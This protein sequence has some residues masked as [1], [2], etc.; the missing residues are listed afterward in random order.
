M[1]LNQT[2]SKRVDLLGTPGAC[3]GDL[4]LEKRSQLAVLVGADG[5][6]LVHG[7]PF[8][9]GPRGGSP[10]VS[11][12]TSIASR[13]PGGSGCPSGSGRTTRRLGSRTETFT[14]TRSRDGKTGAGAAA[15]SCT[16][17]GSDG[18]TSVDP[19]E[20]DPAPPGAGGRVEGLPRSGS[21]GGGFDTAAGGGGGGLEFIFRVPAGRLSP[22]ESVDDGAT[23]SRQR[24]PKWVP[25]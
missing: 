22:T 10:S 4:P 2:R 23:E 25:L 5:Q 19:G 7:D 6:V 3:F 1:E 8:P 18:V 24:K 13:V 12:S 11:A 17:G 21:G 14:D 16:P 15:R 9:C 20:N